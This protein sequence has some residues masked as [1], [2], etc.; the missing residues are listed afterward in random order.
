[1]DEV[2]TEK[3]IHTVCCVLCAVCC[4]LYAALLRCCVLCVLFV[5][6]KRRFLSLFL[7]FPVSFL[8]LFRLFPFS[9]SSLLLSLFLLFSFLF[10]VSFFPRQKA[11][12]NETDYGM[13]ARITIPGAPL[14]LLIADTSSLHC[15]GPSLP[16]KVGLSV[17]IFAPKINQISTINYQLSNI[18]C[19]SKS[20]SKFAYSQRN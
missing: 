12:Q 3:N 17:S 11:I 4:V 18:K 10:L 8:S 2:R 15:R 20:K 9:V 7:L 16:G 5:N 13:K 14:T 19:K 6:I 1:M